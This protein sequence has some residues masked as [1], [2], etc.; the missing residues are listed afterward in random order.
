MYFKKPRFLY[1][2]PALVLASEFLFAK[3]NIDSIHARKS[4]RIDS[5]DST[6]QRGLHSSVLQQRPYTVE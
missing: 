4:I 5:S 6:R 2:F 1:S 3:N